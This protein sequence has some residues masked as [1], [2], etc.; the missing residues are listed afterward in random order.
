MATFDIPESVKYNYMDLNNLQGMDSWDTNPSEMR[1][2][3]ML[4][5]VKKEGLHQVRH[6]INQSYITG[7]RKFKNLCKNFVY[8]YDETT[9]YSILY[10]DALIDDNTTY[11]FSCE[12]K[13]LQYFKLNPNIGTTE[14]TVE[15]SPNR[16]SFTFTTGT[17]NTEQDYIEGKGWKFLICDEDTSIKIN[18]LDLKENDLI[19]R[20]SMAYLNIPT[21]QSDLIEETLDSYRKPYALQEVFLSYLETKNELN[22]T[23]NL[24]ELSYETFWSETPYKTTHKI[25]GKDE[26]KNVITYTNNNRK[27]ESSSKPMIL[28]PYNTSYVD[29]GTMN[30]LDN[31]TIKV[32]V[33]NSGYKIIYPT[34]EPELYPDDYLIQITLDTQ[35]TVTALNGYEYDDSLKRSF[36]LIFRDEVS[37]GS[38]SN[39]K[40]YNVI[41]SS[42][43][44]NFNKTYNEQITYTIPATQDWII[45]NI[46]NRK[47]Y[48]KCDFRLGAMGIDDPV[49]TEIQLFD[50]PL[51]LNTIVDAQ[52]SKTDQTKYVVSLE[53]DYTVTDTSTLADSGDSIDYISYEMNNIYNDLSK[54]QIEEGEQATEFFDSYIDGDDILY[55]IKY[56]GKIEEYDDSGNPVPYY[57]KIS[58]YMGEVDKEND[59]ELIISVWPTPLVK[60]IKYDLKNE[61]GF[62]KYLISYKTY[63]FTNYGISGNRQGLYEHIEFDGKERVFTPIGILSFNCST[64]E[65]EDGFHQLNFEVENVLDN[66]YIPTI[67]YGSTPDGLDY[68]TYE[69]INLLSNKRK[70]QFLSDGKSTT[71]KLPETN[72]EDYCKIKIL[73][74]N[75]TFN[76][77]TEGFTL[78]SRTGVITFTTAPSVS[79]IDG[80]DN[81]IVEYEKK[82]TSIAEDNEFVLNTVSSDNLLKADITINKTIDTDD[83]TKINAQLSIDIYG[84]SVYD[85]SVYTINSATLKI[86]AGSIEVYNVTLDS[87]QLSTI[88]S[89]NKL[90]ITTEV[91]FNNDGAI[92][93]RKWTSTMNVDYTKNTY[94]QTTTTVP[95]SKGGQTSFGTQRKTGL[96][97]SW[98]GLEYNARAVATVGS[99]TN[100]SDSYWDVYV[101]VRLWISRASYLQ[102]RASS[103]YAVVDGQR[104]YAG[105]TGSMYGT[106]TVY[107]SGGLTIKKRIPYSSSKKSVSIGAYLAFGSTT[108]LSGTNYNSMSVGNTTLNLPNITLPKTIT[109]TSGEKT[110]GSTTGS[111]SFNET[112]PDVEDNIVKYDNVVPGSAR[113]ACYYG[114]KCV[115]VYGYESDRRVF[116]SDGTNCDTYSGSTLDG[117]SSITY[118]PDTN[119]RVLG[120]DTEIIGY[121]QK[122]G[123]LFTFKRGDDSVY[124]RYGTTLNDVTEFP[125]SAVTRNLQ[126]LTRPIQ[127]DD[128]IL[129]I[130]RE[131]IKGMSYVSQECRTELRSYFISNYFKL[132]ADYDYD[133]MQWFK[134]D[135]LLHIF[136]NE[137]EFTADMVSKSYV[138]EGTSITGG[139]YSSTLA[140]QYEWY[141]SR[142]DWSTN[143]PPSISV[144]QPKDFERQEEGVV[145]EYQR[146]IG[147]NNKG[148]FEFSYNDYKVDKLMK[149]Q[150]DE[151]SITYTPIKAHYITPFLNMGAINVAKTVK[152]VYINTRSKNG[153][154]FAIGYIDENGYQET[155]EK[156][157]NNINDYPT[158]LKNSEIPFPKLIQIKSKIRKFMNIKLY[159]QNRAEL[160]DI[161][162]IDS[163]EESLYCNTTFDRI[164]IQYQIAGKYRGE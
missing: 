38:S 147:Y 87:T 56:I 128:E 41:N 37:N 50:T 10:T 110:T 155:L 60:N 111:V 6:N 11:T 55:D 78:N 119:Y 131:G 2:S 156:I 125:S 79:P 59:S 74:E 90:T 96:G 123:Y 108:N 142:I 44:N 9:G 107:P 139:R 71:Y 66:P 113:L 17:L 97:F 159:I 136:L 160:E 68:S 1:A 58:E 29:L 3:D 81:V 121:A 54:V 163:S 135:A 141:V 49:T 88:N 99:K 12:S 117:S 48:F 103:L 14:D 75:G 69:A 129:L 52:Y 83:D 161:D 5:I 34:K 7:Y 35:I 21:N 42:W 154:M 80:Q 93:I 45:S 16:S 146:E 15:V 8:E 73:Q 106:S 115:T 104:I 19:R 64:T 94:K 98:I 137:Y 18:A 149:I 145:Y 27:G 13:Y 82:P 26:S 126:V 51:F 164:L 132:S 144:Y 31:F 24:I 151:L 67:G 140:F 57:I 33:K 101:W 20:G 120:E 127:I 40:N 85:K 63:P 92:E 23:N 116:V 39:H 46:T 91:I 105:S 162:T 89:G 153:D 70:F 32:K 152:Y 4:N 133:K 25:T 148:V 36:R 150:D 118:F 84:G 86:V 77:M 109:T 143:S 30:I 157:Y 95:G 130:T 53:H 76:T 114:A 72:L 112:L 22:E 28:T 134:D 47:I 62:E 65:T 122:N 43:Y 138:Q 102:T 124:V 61:Q 158:R 100:G